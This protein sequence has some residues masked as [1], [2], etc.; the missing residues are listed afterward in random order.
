MYNCATIYLEIFLNRIL[1]GVDALGFAET[2]KALSDPVRRQILVLLKDGK[3]SA[4]DIAREVDMAGA[5]VG[6]GGGGG[7]GGGYCQ[8]V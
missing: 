3:K 7:G 4:G 6:G 1:K 5:G 8:G 2:F